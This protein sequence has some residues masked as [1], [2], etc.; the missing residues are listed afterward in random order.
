M[1]ISRGAKGAE[2][3][4]VRRRGG[5]T[6]SLPGEG[7]RGLDPSP[8]FVLLFVLK[9]EHFGAVFKLDCSCSTAAILHF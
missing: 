5:D 6:P 7:S 2:K 3:G 4:G 8:E 1:R 9:V